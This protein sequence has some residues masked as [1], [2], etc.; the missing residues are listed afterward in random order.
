[1]KASLGL[2]KAKVLEAKKMLI[3]IN[4]Q[5]MAGHVEKEYMAQEPEL[6]KY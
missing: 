2:N 5:V 1:M 6:F 3:K 4:S